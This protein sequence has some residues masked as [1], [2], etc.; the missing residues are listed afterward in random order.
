MKKLIFIDNS[1]LDQFIL[2]RV[3][4]KYKLPYEVN[5]TADADEVIEYLE[6]NRSDSDNL[7]D[8]ILLDIYMP[9]LDGWAFLEKVQSLYPTL[10]K[11]VKFYMLS[12]VINP[13]DIQRAKHFSCVRSFIFKPITKEALER[14]IDEEVANESDHYLADGSL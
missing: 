11:P 13:A 4:N 5:C 6:H 8:V 12:S 3:L 7:P 9:Q 14:L 1:P 10:S 2:E